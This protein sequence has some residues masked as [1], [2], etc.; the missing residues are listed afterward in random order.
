[1][2]NSR[3]LNIT[4]QITEKGRREKAFKEVRKLNSVDLH[5]IEVIS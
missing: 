4:E 2:P 5:C 1:M 3:I